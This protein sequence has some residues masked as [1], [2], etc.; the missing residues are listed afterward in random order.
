[1]EERDIPN[2]EEKA[3]LD[4]YLYCIKN[5]CDQLVTEYHPP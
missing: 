4:S 5:I 3:L 1:M 2:E